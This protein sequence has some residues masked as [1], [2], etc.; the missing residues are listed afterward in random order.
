M[1]KR[2]SEAEE[3]WAE[4][5][6]WDEDEGWPEGGSENARPKAATKQVKPSKVA[7]VKPSE[8]E[9]WETWEEP[10]AA[11]W[12][13]AGHAAAAAANSWNGAD[14]TSSWAGV[15]ARPF[16]NSQDRADIEQWLGCTPVGW[17][18]PGTPLVPCKTPF[19]GPL[20]DRAYS[21][22]LLTDK[23]WF[24]KAELVKK[25][26]KQETPIGLVID[27]VNTD[28]YYKGF[29]ES[30]DG[31]E[32][33]KFRIPGRTVPPREAMEEIFDAIDGFVARRPDEYVAVHCTHGVNR[34]G[35]LI[36]AYLMT[37]GHLRTRQKAVSTFEYARGMKMD[38]EY[39]IEALDMLQRGEY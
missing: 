30:L 16:V 21:A 25:C 38:K 7:K 31:I 14:A 29:S 17:N 39:L 33:Q 27:M 13:G 5:T 35:F 11:P 12:P 23:Q 36:A 4:E 3:L 19:E 37:R 2:K 10:A 26:R 22:G 32:Y 8:E 15:A 1:A 34:T 20:A 18:V 9:E 6:W 28:K 24:G